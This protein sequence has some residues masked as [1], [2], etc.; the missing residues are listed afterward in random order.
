VAKAKALMAP[1]AVSVYAGGG[2]IGKIVYYAL[3]IGFF[4]RYNVLLA[5]S[6]TDF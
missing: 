4:L 3:M 5:G 6:K 1:E 2:D